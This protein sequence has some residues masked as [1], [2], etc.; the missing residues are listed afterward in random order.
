MKV[1]DV[2]IPLNGFVLHCASFAYQDAVVISTDPLILASED[3]TMRWESTISNKEF[4]V[5]GT[6]DEETLNNCLRRL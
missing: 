6:A 3:S 1:G 4:E 5:I 2:V